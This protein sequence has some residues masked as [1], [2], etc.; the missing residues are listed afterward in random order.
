VHEGA[1]R[2]AFD[3]AVDA[4]TPSCT[5]LHGR[6][7][8]PRSE[9]SEKKRTSRAESAQLE[10]EGRALFD[11]GDAAAAI[12]LLRNRSVLLAKHAPGALPCL[13]ARCLVPELDSARSGETEYQRDFVVSSSR[14]LFYWAPAELLAN[15][16]QLRASMRAT[17]R[18]RLDESRRQAG[19]AR[20]GINPFTGDT[21]EIPAATQRASLNPFT[22]KRDR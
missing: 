20:E 8:Q 16:R 5:V 7:A 9:R 13:C 14:T 11:A 3:A 15:R 10:T 18:L 12:E 2:P 17:L 1:E 19:V 4:L 6:M 21:I 22:G